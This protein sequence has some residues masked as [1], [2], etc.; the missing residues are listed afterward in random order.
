MTGLHRWL[1]GRPQSWGKFLYRAIQGQNDVIYHHACLLEF[2][3][4]SL[5]SNSETPQI[6]FTYLYIFFWNTSTAITFSSEHDI[7]RNSLFGLSLAAGTSFVTSICYHEQKN[8][9]EDG[10]D[11][12]GSDS[13]RGLDKTSGI[14]CNLKQTS[15]WVIF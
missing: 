12:K 9:E 2:Y 14:H 4:N 10:A 3:F 8:Q 15:H 6:E 13:F 1:H 5:K 7:R 11:D